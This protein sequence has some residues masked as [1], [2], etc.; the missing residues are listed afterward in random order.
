MHNWRLVEQLDWT[1][2]KWIQWHFVGKHSTVRVWR[3]GLCDLHLHS[4]PPPHHPPPPC[5]ASH[6]PIILL[7]SDFS[8]KG[9][10][11]Y[12]I[13]KLWTCVICDKPQ[14]T[15]EQ[16]CQWLIKTWIRVEDTIG[17]KGQR[18]LRQR[19]LNFVLVLAYLPHEWYRCV[20]L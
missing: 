11:H 19:T 9:Y 12:I 3:E 18:R 6:Y 8:E 14:F 17:C 2:C 10:L 15:N 4:H 1:S 7:P 16:Y 20:L 13:A 5:L